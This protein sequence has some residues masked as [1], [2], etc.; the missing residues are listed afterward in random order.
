LLPT[1]FTQIIH[2]YGSFSNKEETKVKGDL[3]QRGGEFEKLNHLKKTL[4]DKKIK[5]I[6][7][8]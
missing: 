7:K 6:V 8:T 2:C 5:Y 4:P 3:Q 1:L